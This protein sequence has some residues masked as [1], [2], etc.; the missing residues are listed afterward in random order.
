MIDA[1][2]QALSIVFTVEGILII[3][4]GAMVGTLVGAI[5]GLGGAITLALLIPFSFALDSN[6]GILLLIAALGGVNYG[7]SI[8]A[9]MLNI[10]G[11]APSVITTI[12]GYQMS[13]NNQ[14]GMALG[15]SAAASAAGAIIGLVFLMLMIP[16]VTQI[17][18]LFGPP[19]FL[20]VSVIGLLIVASVLKGSLTNGLIG[21]A[22]GVTLGFH[23]FNSITG[24]LRFDFGILY[25][26]DG[27]PLM[28]LIIGLFAISEMIVLSRDGSASLSD[29]VDLGESP[30]KGVVAVF[31]NWKLLFKSAVIGI[32]I[33]V[34]PAIGATVSTLIAYSRAKAGASDPSTFGKGDVRGVIAPE[35]SN[36]AKD[37]ASLLPT[38]AFS[39]PG[40]P[41]HAVLLGGILVHGVTPGPSLF[42][43]ANIYVVFLMVFGLLFSNLITSGVGL[44]LAKQVVKIANVPPALIIP[45]VVV[46]SMFGAYAYRG[47]PVDM[48]LVLIMGLFGYLTIKAEISRIAILFGMILGPIIEDTFHQTMQIMRID[49]SR[50]LNS[51]VLVLILI[52]IVGMFTYRYYSARSA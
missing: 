48:V 3:A 38:L 28:L 22:L 37:G 51:S 20:V 11:T 29:E 31:Q 14:G 2:V 21:V 32:I 12:D 44:V 33:G 15:A 18:L 17:L 24:G 43:S 26:Y 8:P 46:L 42:E 7:G 40:S 13:K 30:M 4:L 25:L 45:S 27:I 49:S 36:D 39:I 23:G 47:N 34:I 41:S 6:I 16:V 9:I 5:P 52:L 10:P 50:V 35:G 19:E 1:I